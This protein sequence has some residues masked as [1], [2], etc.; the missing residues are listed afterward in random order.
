MRRQPARTVSG[1]GLPGIWIDAREVLPMSRE[2]T[3]ISRVK[4]RMLLERFVE[5]RTALGNSERRVFYRLDYPK[6]LKSA[7][8]ANSVVRFAD[9]VTDV[10]RTWMRRNQRGHPYC[11]Q[12]ALYDVAF[13]EASIEALRLWPNRIILASKVLHFAKPS[14]FPIWDT[15]V[16]HALGISA[17]Y[18][19]GRYLDWMDATHSVHA[20]LQ[21]RVTK[22][23][24]EAVGY[25]V[26]PV[27]AIEAAVFDSARD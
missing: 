22:R 4:L 21:K 18:N 12:R 11:F 24:R 20:A 8:G 16:A 3:P 19:F 15:F 10:K 26:T 7:S 1:F 2:L 9:F 5:G 14:T 17:P 6:K 23:Y 25:D 27:R 13:K